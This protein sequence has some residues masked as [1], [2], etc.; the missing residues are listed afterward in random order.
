MYTP[1][2]AAVE[3]FWSISDSIFKHFP[4]YLYRIVYK[5]FCRSN[6]NQ[7]AVC[8][9]YSEHVC[10]CTRG[11]HRRA[12]N[13]HVRQVTNILAGMIVDSQLVSPRILTLR[14]G[15]DVLTQVSW[16][17]S[18]AGG[19]WRGDPGPGGGRPLHV[20]PPQSW[21]GCSHASRH[22]AVRGQV[23]YIRA[24]PVNALQ[25]PSTQ[26]FHNKLTFITRR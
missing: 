25:S 11:V 19:I 5:I 15:S 20:R 14:C 26:Q 9:Q 3:N 18:C 21:L 4:Y 17:C 22:N 6:K 23:L 2:G 12:A 8:T 10:P 1:P 13:H 16:L 7:S 24:V